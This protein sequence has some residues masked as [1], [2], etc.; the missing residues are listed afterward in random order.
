MQKTR[1]TLPDLTS[2][3]DIDL[4]SYARAGSPDAFRMIMQRHNRRLYR[5][6]R[7]VTGND[8][9][10]EDVVQESYLCAFTH[11]D[12]FRGEARLSTWLTRIIL[13]KALAR[14]RRR[15]EIFDLS[16]LERIDDGRAQILMFPQPSASQDPEAEAGRAQLRRLV[17]QALDDLPEAFR[18][19]FVMREIEEMSIEETASHLGIRPETVKTRL[20]R[21]RRL[22]QKALH[23][24][25]VVT[26]KDAFPFDG[27]RCNR[28][29]DRVMQRL[30]LKP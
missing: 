6:A 9:E 3:T 29:T 21:A 27:S 8:I 26:L 22:L 1:T 10:A 19:V 5:V 2:L 13:N 18:S 23:A 11:L 17:E 24:Q 30:E 20:H 14:V 4:V 7:G 28:V 15:R 12:T 16:T 25:F